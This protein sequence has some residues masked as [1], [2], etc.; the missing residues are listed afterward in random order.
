M[1]PR[2][3]LLVGPVCPPTRLSAYLVAGGDGLF[4]LV[5]EPRVGRDGRELALV[6][7]RG[8]LGQRPDVVVGEAQ[9]LDLGDHSYVTSSVGGGDKTTDRLCEYVNMTEEREKGIKK[10]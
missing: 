2:Y 6:D 9:R 5:G 4:E 7:G 10:I 1:Q 3:I 8:R